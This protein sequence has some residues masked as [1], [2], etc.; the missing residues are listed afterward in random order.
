MT[1]NNTY[2]RARQGPGTNS[3]QPALTLFH[4]NSDSQGVSG[5]P[6]RMLCRVL[7]EPLTPASSPKHLRYTQTKTHS[8]K[9]LTITLPKH[10]VH[11]KTR[12]AWN[13]CN[14]KQVCSLLNSGVHVNLLVLTD[15]AWLCRINTRENGVMDITGILSCLC[16][17][18]IYL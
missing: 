10:H 15:V 12:K 5:T 18:P 14:P 7:P 4:L 16:N 2:Q 3:S 9:Y 8:T 17:F 11:K 6:D 1:T 13:W